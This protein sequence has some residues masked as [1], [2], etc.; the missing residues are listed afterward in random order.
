[1][2]NMPKYNTIDGDGLLPSNQTFEAHI[3][4]VSAH[5]IS[6]QITT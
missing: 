2:L 1:M 6:S 4:Y 3:I 5:M